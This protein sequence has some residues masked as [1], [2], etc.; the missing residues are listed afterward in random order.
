MIPEPPKQPWQ[1]RLHETAARV[2]EEIRHMVEY[3]NDEVVP[4]VR[5]YSSEALRKAAIEL[6]KLA[7]RMD[8]NRGEAPPPPKP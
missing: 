4:D 6:D 2:E 1:E 5:R 8:D 3:M 7:Q